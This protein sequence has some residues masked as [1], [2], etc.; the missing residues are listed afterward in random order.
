VPAAAADRPETAIIFYDLKSNGSRAKYFRSAS[1]A[2]S[3]ESIS[4]LNMAKGILLYNLFRV[5]LHNVF[6][7]CFTHLVF[8]EDGV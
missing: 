2:Y 4:R 7:S 3:G 5:M 1:S 6:F 8:K